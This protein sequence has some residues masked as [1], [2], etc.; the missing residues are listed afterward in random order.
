VALA[1]LAG[2]K[3]DSV[4]PFQITRDN[5]IT[6]FRK[7]I[8]SKF[9][10]PN[11][12]KQLIREESF[13]ALY[14][15]SWSFSANTFSH[16]HGTLGRTVTRQHNGRSETT[17]QWFRVHS[18]IEQTYLDYSVQS[19]DRIPTN[20]FNRL[21]PFNLALLKVYRQEY[22]SGIAA[23]HY[24]R[25]IESCFGDFAN[26]VRRDLRGRI[27]NRHN[28]TQAQQ[29]QINTTYNNKKFNY[30]LLPIYIANY[31]YKGK[32]FN[33]YVNGASGKVVGKY[34]KSFWKVFLAALGVGAIIGGVI[35]G[36]WLIGR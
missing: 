25:D 27:M 11:K 19:G 6:R 16:Y 32:L 17:T 21:K 24:A 14:S 7:W 3:P 29:L 22:L 23:E 10:A 36:V 34:P 18:S 13:N 4:I 8:K 15:S 2:I 9:F 33:F 26:F 12:L 1:E 35:L 30:I 5:A 31:K 20:M 28:A